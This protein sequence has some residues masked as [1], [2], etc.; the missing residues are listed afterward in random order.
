MIRLWHKFNICHA[1]DNT[2]MS[3]MRKLASQ[4]VTFKRKYLTLNLRKN[5]VVSKTVWCG[6]GPV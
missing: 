6:R 4:E 2:E 1:P 3:L 5:S